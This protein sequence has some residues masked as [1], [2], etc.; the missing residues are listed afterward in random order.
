MSS[1]AQNLESATRTN[2]KSS[3][4][5]KLVQAA[6]LAAVLVP[7]G[8]VAI[9]G[10][11]IYCD[12]N[13]GSGSCTG[14]FSSGNTSNTWKFFEDSSFDPSE[15]LYSFTLSGAVTDPFSLDVNDIV[16]TQ[17]TLAPRLAPFF[18]NAVCVPT[19]DP[20][21]CGYFRV[22]GTDG[23][24]GGIYDLEISWF[25]N[26]DPLSVPTNAFVLQ[27]K[28]GFGGVF[29]NTL[30]NPFYNPN[31]T[32]EDPVVGGRGDSFSDFLASTT[33][34]IPE[35]ASLLLLGSGL[36]AM[37][38]KRSRRRRASDTAPAV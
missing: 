7:L 32:P 19:N 23:F 27:A 12:T 28:N 3:T 35:P 30:S 31:P 11:V 14:F 18:P 9:E 15:L 16:E 17:A 13:P 29:T 4:A 33:N 38:Y 26:S 24:D 20:G 34:P 6:A 36:G 5:R 8:S 22:T 25:S 37:L 10:S 2:R 1:H 21:L